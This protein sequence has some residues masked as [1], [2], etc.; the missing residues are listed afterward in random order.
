LNNFSEYGVLNQNFSEHFGFTNEEVDKLLENNLVWL[1]D[2]EKNQ[3]KAAIKD[4]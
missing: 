3:Q 2:M 4:W 1:N